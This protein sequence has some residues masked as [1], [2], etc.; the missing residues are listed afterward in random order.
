MTSLLILIPFALI[1]VFLAVV[2]YLWAINHDQYT[3]LDREASRILFD[4][5]SNTNQED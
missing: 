3:D 1:L 4:E 5:I 2:T